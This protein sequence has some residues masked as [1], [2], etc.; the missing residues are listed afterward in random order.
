MML[1]DKKYGWLLDDSRIG[2]TNQLR[3]ICSYLT[4]NI[5]IIEKNLIWKNY[6]IT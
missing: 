6:N 2:N 4:N 1:Q 5:N 3:A